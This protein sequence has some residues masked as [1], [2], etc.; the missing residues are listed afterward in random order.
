MLSTHCLKLTGAN[1]PIVP[2]LTTTMI[3]NIF[4]LLKWE[5]L[6]HFVNHII[7]KTSGLLY[8]RMDRKKCILLHFGKIAQLEIWSPFCTDLWNK[9]YVFDFFG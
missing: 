7:E 9:S 6:C 1:A 4:H 2:I 5:K 8:F 3:L